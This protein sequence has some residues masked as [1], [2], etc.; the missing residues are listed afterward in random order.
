MA[1][2]GVVLFISNDSSAVPVVD[3]AASLGATVT[4]ST[5]EAVNAIIAD[6][7]TESWYL[8]SVQRK[9]EGPVEGRAR[10]Q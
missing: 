8:V 9:Q 10:Q 4:H 6:K 3:L 2:E 1:L 5:T 7:V